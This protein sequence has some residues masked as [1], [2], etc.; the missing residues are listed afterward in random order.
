MA[1][2]PCRVLGVLRALGA[3]GHGAGRVAGRCW[4]TAENSPLPTLLPGGRCAG[5]PASP[6]RAQSLAGGPAMAQGP[7]VLPGQPAPEV[8]YLWGVTGGLGCPLLGLVP[9]PVLLPAQAAA[10][11]SVLLWTHQPAMGNKGLQR[12]CASG[13]CTRSQWKSGAT[14]DVGLHK[15]M[16]CHGQGRGVWGMILGRMADSGVGTRVVLLACSHAGHSHR[17]K[18]YKPNHCFPLLQVCPIHGQAV[19]GDPTTV[20]PQSMVHPCPPHW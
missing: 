20:G 19:L 13:D 10:S 12:G 1:H 11:H 14:P 17:D 9:S 5:G 3:A 8:L 16:P 15:G 2:F 6:D 4:L 7:G 18:T